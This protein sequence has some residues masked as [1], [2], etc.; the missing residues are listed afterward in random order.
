[1]FTI[2]FI[3]AKVDEADMED[4]GSSWSG[5]YDGNAIYNY[6]LPVMGL[7][8]LSVVPRRTLSAATSNASRPALQAEGRKPSGQRRSPARLR[9]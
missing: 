3:K 1:M 4:M 2:A 6:Y 5:K 9:L 7:V 8:G